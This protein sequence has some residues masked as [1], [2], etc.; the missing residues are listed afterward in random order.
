MRKLRTTLA[1][2]AVALV[3]AS[4]GAAAAATPPDAWI[5]TKARLALITSYMVVLW[6]IAASSKGS[7]CSTPRFGDQASGVPRGSC[8][9]RVRTAVRDRTSPCRNDKLRTRAAT[10]RRRAGA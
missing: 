2:W 4:A 6:R 5:T 10:R 7:R 8:C 1:P 3:L 9:V